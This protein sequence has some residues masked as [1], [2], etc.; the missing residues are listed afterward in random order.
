MREIGGFLEFDVN[1][2]GSPYHTEALALTSGRACMS[3]I[4]SKIQPTKIYL[5]YYICNTVLESINAFDVP[6]QF[7]EIDKDLFPKRKIDLA[8]GEYIVGVNYYGTNS[9]LIDR[10]YEA[11]GNKL[12]VDNSQSYYS[13]QYKDCWSFNSARKFFGVPDGAYLYGP[14][15]QTKEVLPANTEVSYEHLLSRLAGA[16]IAAY[17]QYQNNEAGF[18]AKILGMSEITQK[19]LSHT[20]H[21]EAA[22]KRI[23]NYNVLESLLGKMNIRPETLNAGDIP[24]CYPFYPGKDLDRSELISERIYVPY[25]WQD[26]RD[27]CLEEYIFENQLVENM[28]PLPIDQRYNEDDMK[29]MADILIKTMAT[30]KHVYC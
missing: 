9:V 22:K 19:L 26:K 10:L 20:N 11:F 13:R 14:D 27:N 23:E 30:K 17:H 29:H 18:T 28:M 5:P 7:F 2:E 8:G 24:L 6:Y 4:M 1:G 12:I 3:F 21:E 25:F 16:G 15:L